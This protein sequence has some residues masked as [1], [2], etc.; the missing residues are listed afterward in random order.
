MGFCGNELEPELE[1]L[2]QNS[3]EDRMNDLNEVLK[4]HESR[5]DQIDFIQ[6]ELKRIDTIVSDR[7]SCKQSQS[8]LTTTPVALR[9]LFSIFATWSAG[10][11]DLFYWDRL[12]E[13]MLPAIMFNPN[14][15]QKQKR[16][17][18][19]KHWHSN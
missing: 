18:K 17:R 11:A 3:F 10:R 14:V 15:S 16:I 7:V 13:L 6:N 5:L 2:I 8:G 4:N 12:L 19:S 1:N 9:F